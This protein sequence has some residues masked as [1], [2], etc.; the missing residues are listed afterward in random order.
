MCSNSSAFENHASCSIVSQCGRYHLLMGR[1]LHCDSEPHFLI[2][3]A[4]MAFIR[5]RAGVPSECAVEKGQY[6]LTFASSVSQQQRVRSSSTTRKSEEILGKI[7]LHPCPLPS[8]KLRRVV[9]LIYNVTCK[10][11]QI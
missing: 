11:G 4:V 3:Q 9:V 1:C 7:E 8:R 5:A 6:V 2:F 10:M